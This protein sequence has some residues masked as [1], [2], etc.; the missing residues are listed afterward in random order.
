[1]LLGVKDIINVDGYPTRCG[2]ALPHGLFDG[3]QASCVTRLCEAGAIVVGK[4]VTAEFAISDPG[5]T[6]NPRNLAHTPGGSSSGSAAA[7]AAGFCDIAIG[8]QTSGST[9]RPAGYCGVIGYKPSFGRI[10]RDG[11]FP[12]STSMDHVGLFTSNLMTLQAVV[13]LLVDNWHQLASS[14]DTPVC[15]GIPEG[16]YIDL[17]TKRVAEQFSNVIGRLLW[18]VTSS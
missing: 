8:T 17:A 9:I 11:V 7:V 12:F 6:R 16:S 13:P 4:T 1:M 3:P 10:A 14:V 2:S 15:I 18:S 5:A